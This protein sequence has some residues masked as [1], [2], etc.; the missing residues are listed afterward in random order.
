MRRNP[1]AGVLVLAH[2]PIL[3]PASAIVKCGTILRTLSA[4]GRT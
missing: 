2:K 3:S 4:A 1:V